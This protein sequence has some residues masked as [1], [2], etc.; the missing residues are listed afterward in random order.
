LDVCETRDVKGLYK[1]ARAG[2]IPNFTG[3]SDPYEPPE[4][5]ELDVRTDLLT[6]D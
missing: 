2:K 6:L 5:P 3:V 4:N 1:L